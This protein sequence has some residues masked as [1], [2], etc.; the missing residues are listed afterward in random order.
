LVPTAYQGLIDKIEDTI[1]FAVKFENGMDPTDI[2]NK[3]DVRM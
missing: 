2:L 3:Q 1:D